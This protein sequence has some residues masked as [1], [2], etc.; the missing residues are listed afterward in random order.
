MNNTNH[1]NDYPLLIPK[2]NVTE[3]KELFNIQIWTVKDAAKALDISVGHIYNL[4]CK[5]MIP[6]HQKGKKGRLYFIP[7]EI[8]EWIHEGEFR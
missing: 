8:L 7:S 3:R 5:K 2:L 1:Q 6:F 4:V